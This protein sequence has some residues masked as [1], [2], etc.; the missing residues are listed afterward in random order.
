M[1]SLSTKADPFSYAD[2]YSHLLTHEFFYK[3][4]LQFIGVVIIAPLLLMPA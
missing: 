4:S 1:T 2:L 3:S